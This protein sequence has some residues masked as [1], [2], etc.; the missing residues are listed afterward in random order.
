MSLLLF[1][2]NTTMIYTFIHYASLFGLHFHKVIYGWWCEL[3][4]D[5]SCYFSIL[6]LSW[7]SVSST[8]LIKDALHTAV[9]LQSSEIETVSFQH[10]TTRALRRKWQEYETALSCRQLHNFELVTQ[11]IP[12]LQIGCN[13]ICVEKKDFFLCYH[14]LH[15]ENYNTKKN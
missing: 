1:L 6:A 8:S 10:S 11:R 2:P 14:F 13:S 5:F 12:S 4:R 9:L 15:T 7:A 3:H